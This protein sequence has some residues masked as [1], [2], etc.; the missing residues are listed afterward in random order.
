MQDRDILLDIKADV[1]GL[2]SD[3]ASLRAWMQEHSKGDEAVE[4]RV[5]ELEL[6]HAR[7]KGAASVWLMI[8][9][10]VGAA[11]GAI[12]PG[13]VEWFKAKGGS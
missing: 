5:R 10:G 2:K 1:G 6:K 7:H 8:A 3:M 13:A 9:T 4:A 12:A 11:I